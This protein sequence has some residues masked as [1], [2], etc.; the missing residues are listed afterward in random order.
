M[1]SENETPVEGEEPGPVER[2]LF[3]VH[4]TVTT[5]KLN[6]GTVYYVDGDHYTVD[7]TGLRIFKAAVEGEHADTL[8]LH[9]APGGWSSIERGL[10][11]RRPM[12]LLPLTEG[13]W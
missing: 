11:T 12:P 13:G 9:V 10:T 3:V 4:G 5:G 1:T 8:V 2:E 7:A 6:S